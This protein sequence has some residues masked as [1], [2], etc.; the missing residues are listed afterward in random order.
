MPEVWIASQTGDSVIVFRNPT[1]AGY[2]E[3]REHRRG[4]MVSPQA[5]PDLS[6]SVEEILGRR[7]HSQP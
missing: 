5:F 4:E 6:L 7:R 2:Q 3:I 1:P